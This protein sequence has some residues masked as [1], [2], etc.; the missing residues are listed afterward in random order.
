MG[1][2]RRQDGLDDED[3]DLDQGGTD[4]HQADDGNLPET[5]LIPFAVGG[6][7]CAGCIRRRFL[8]EEDQDDEVQ[9][10]GGC[11]QEEG[12]A[13]AEDFGQDT[14]EE[15]ADDAACRQGALHDAQADAQFLRRRI[16]G[17]D[18]QFHGPQ[19]R[20]EALEHAHEGQLQRRRDDAAEEVADR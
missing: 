1:N 13:H 3:D 7:V 16:N 17:H 18:G 12:H 8:D 14:A 9:E 19:A 4:Q 15:G 20:G 10:Q 5:D 6:A 2:V 11:G